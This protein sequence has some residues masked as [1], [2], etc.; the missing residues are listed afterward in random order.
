MFQAFRQLLSRARNEFVV[1]DTAP[2]GHTLLLLDVTGSFHRQVIEGVGQQLRG[3]VTPLMRL[4]DPDYS[5]VVIVTLAETTPVAEA[6][7]LQEDLRRAAIEPFGWV[8]NATLAG[9]GTDDPILGS[10]SAL[11]R[12]QLDRVAEN[13]K[14]MW[15]LPWSPSIAA[16]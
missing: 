4:Q 9:S 12:I 11:E 8:V 7:E 13:T 2:T 6:T 14:R 10:R 15:S 1:I 5:R 3:V 16:G